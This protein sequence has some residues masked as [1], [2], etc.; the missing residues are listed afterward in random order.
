MS[1]EHGSGG[2]A[3]RLPELTVVDGSVVKTVVGLDE[4]TDVRPAHARRDFLDHDC[5]ADVPSVF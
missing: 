4:P 3:V 2:G 5:S 1:D